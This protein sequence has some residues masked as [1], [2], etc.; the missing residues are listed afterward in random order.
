MGKI[1]KCAQHFD[2]IQ[3]LLDQQRTIPEIAQAIGVT[4]LSLQAFLQR[5]AIRSR[6][7][8]TTANLI[9][10]SRLCSLI[11]SGATHQQAAEALGVHYSSVEKRT[12][13]LGLENSRTGPRAG[14]NHR[15]WKAGRAIDKHGYVEVFAPLH[16][17]ARQ[18]SGRVFEHRLLAEVMT[19]RYLSRDEVIDNI[20]GHPR[21]NWPSNLRVFPS[22]ATHLKAELTGRQKATPRRS[23]PGAYGSTQ[24]IDHCP[25]ES[26]TLAQC[27]SEIRQK[28]A[29]HIQIHQPTSA[30]RTLSRRQ[31]L[32]SG[33]TEEPF[34]PQS[35]A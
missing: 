7:P 27:P 13:R 1:S 21:H 11:E 20:D 4:K 14:R 15:E 35:K 10:D 29:R 32:R 16:P 22:N 28:L 12:K 17:Y 33:A 3:G 23:I 25:S 19:G 8:R 34:P 26:E 31:V 24:T 6:R 30:H 2:R 9:D 5:R 18:G